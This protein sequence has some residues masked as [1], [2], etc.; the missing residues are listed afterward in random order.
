MAITA[1]N[2]QPGDIVPAYGRIMWSFTSDKTTQP[3]FR[4]VIDVYIN[5]QLW[6]RLKQLPNPSGYCVID[7]GTV[8]STALSSL[9]EFPVQASTPI[10][11]TPDS[12]KQ[13]YLLVGEEWSTGTGATSVAQ[14]Y[15]GFD[16]AGN[17]SYGTK[18]VR[19]LNSYLD[20]DQAWDT[21]LNSYTPGAGTTQFMTNVPRGSVKC[22]ITDHFTLQYINRILP[23]ILGVPV[24]KDFIYAFEI[25][26]YNSSNTVIYATT[27]FNDTSTGGG[28]WTACYTP[29]P[30]L[31]SQFTQRLK[32]G[33]A[34][35]PTISTL[36]NL[37]Y[38]TVRGLTWSSYTSPSGPC[39]PN[40]TSSYT[41]TFRI[42]VEPGDCSGFEPIQF[43]WLNKFGG[44][45]YYTFVKRNTETVSTKKSTY[46]ILPGNWSGSTFSQQTWDRGAS[47]A[48]SE[49]EV[50]YTAQTDW[51]TEEESSWLKELAKSPD[52]RAW[53]NGVYTTVVVDTVDY[54]VKTYAR[55]KVFQYQIGFR[56]S[57]TPVV[58]TV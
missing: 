6:T 16:Q 58:Q 51:L 23:T 11:N 47:V 25:K 13:L 14:I 43:E 5:G 8:A 17:P 55:E 1:T 52:V 20:T 30:W 18:T 37:A 24:N 12:S 39:N 28:P 48:A 57:L 46:Q 21:T 40:T 53:I 45:D 49:V 50:K 19:I 10:T 56:S 33:P 15:N 34:D 22:E 44:F 29:G 9:N 35:L 31:T 41:E 7:I 54:E 42:D 4:Y 3:N 2:Q 26:A 36:P 27:L 38:Y 32:C